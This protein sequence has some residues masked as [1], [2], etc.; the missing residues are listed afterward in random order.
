M[1]VVGVSG[2]I[3]FWN[4]ENDRRQGEPFPWGEAVKL[5]LIYS[6][7]AVVLLALFGLALYFLGGG[8]GC[9][10]TDVD[11]VCFDEPAQYGP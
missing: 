1:V 6:I 8:N 3:A 7:A 9:V 10:S 5:T 2:V 11:G 4:A